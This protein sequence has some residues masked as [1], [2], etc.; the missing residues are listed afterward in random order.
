[1]KHLEGLMYWLR[2][3]MYN[4]K[5][6][7]IIAFTKSLHAINQLGI[8]SALIKP[9]DIRRNHQPATVRS[10]TS[11]RICRSPARQDCSGGDG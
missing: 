7:A 3:K 9:Y 10:G 2:N 4:L 5:G 8:D 11:G 1:M 6:A